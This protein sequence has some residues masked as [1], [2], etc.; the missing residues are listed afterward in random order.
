MTSFV[1]I[2]K[3]SEYSAEAKGHPTECT[4]T[5]DGQIQSRDSH[6]VTITNSAGDSK[7]IATKASADIHFDSHSHS[8]NSEDGCHDDNSHDLDPDSG[9]A[10]SSVTINGSPVYIVKNAVTTDP[11]SG[12]DV[13]ITGAGINTSVTES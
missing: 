2:D 10:S 7:E 5:V 13:N 9:K 4:E 6:N 12:G 8:H 1:T 11:G 3:S